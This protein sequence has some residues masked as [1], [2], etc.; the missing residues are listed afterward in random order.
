MGVEQMQG[1]K[2]DGCVRMPVAA[3]V[4][5][6][7]YVNVVLPVQRT[8]HTDKKSEHSCSRHEGRSDYLLTL[9]RPVLEVNGRWVRRWR[10]VGDAFHLTRQRKLLPPRCNQQYSLPPVPVD[11]ITNGTTLE[12]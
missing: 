4:L 7:L 6:V 5:P 11:S 3:F 9:P 10:R 1:P 2:E 8:V 12:A